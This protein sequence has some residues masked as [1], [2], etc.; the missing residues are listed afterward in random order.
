MKIIDVLSEAKER[1]KNIGIENSIY[2]ARILLSKVLNKSLEW[3]MIHINEEVNDVDRQCFETLINRRILGEP[4]QYI[5]GNCY[6]FGYEFSV[7]EA[8]LVP[9]SDTEV[10]V[11]KVIELAKKIKPNSILDL[12]TG[13]GC[14]AITLKKELKD[15][16]VYGSDI[17]EKALAVA[18]ENAYKN[19]AD[20]EFF[21]SDLFDEIENK[22]FDIIVSNPPY[23]PS[24]D[25]SSLSTDVQKEPRIALDGGKDG[26]MFYRKITKEAKK[27]LKTQGYLVFEFG[28]N[29]AEDVKEILTENG[30]NV[31]EIIKDYSGN[32][33]AIISKKGENDE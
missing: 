3:V 1:L 23:I 26:L 15:V 14:I 4:F 31:L 17:S 6:F 21:K 22:K 12:C 33:R 5:I 29:Q 18:K 32:T 7:N 8:V 2:E 28:Y 20:V 13:S 27:Y 25:I 11:E 19:K 24:E 10:W 16:L 30:F 9:R